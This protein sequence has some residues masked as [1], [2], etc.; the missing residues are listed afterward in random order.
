M[1]KKAAKGVMAYRALKDMDPE[2]LT[3][4]EAQ[5][6]DGIKVAAVVTTVIIGKLLLDNY[7]M[8]RELRAIRQNQRVILFAVSRK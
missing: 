8:K 7:V 2:E 5:L 6:K 1:I 4:I 3:E